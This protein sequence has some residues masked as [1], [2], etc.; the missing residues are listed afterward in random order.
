V[1]SCPSSERSLR[2]R[3]AHKFGAREDTLP[4]MAHIRLI[5]RISLRDVRPRRLEHINESGVTRQLAEIGSQWML[6][7]L[8]GVIF[9][10]KVNAP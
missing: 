5:Y 10:K 6:A 2:H 9:R 7:D 1:A 3:A 4:I 8:S